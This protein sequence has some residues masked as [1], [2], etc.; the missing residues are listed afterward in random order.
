MTGPE[1]A[2]RLQI[3]D[4]GEVRV[5]PSSRVRLAATGP[6]EHRL[7]L[8]RGSLSAKVKAPPRL[9]LVDTPNGRASDLGCA[10]DL[11]VDE[12]GGV[13]LVVTSGA[14]E[15]SDRSSAVMVPAGA[16]C[17]AAPNGVPGTPV[18]TDSSPEFRALLKDLDDELWE[19]GSMSKVLVVLASEAAGPGDDLTLWHLIP[20]VE[21]AA[22]Q[23]VI[24]A[25]ARLIPLPSGL[26]PQDAFDLDPETLR[27]WREA[28]D[29]G[30]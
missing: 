22:R 6:D 17:R 21:E 9:F 5:S 4:I 3:A 30:G 20:R 24:M 10:Y 8:A 2:A 23:H 18:R 11:T 25:L 27:R 7:F 28:T 29:W 16:R 14:V 19:T 26:S 13:T 15:L 12:R 1:D